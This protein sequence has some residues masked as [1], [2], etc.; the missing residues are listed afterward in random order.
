[1]AVDAQLPE[2]HFVSVV[3][4]WLIENRLIRFQM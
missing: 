3:S 2:R 4:W 1:M